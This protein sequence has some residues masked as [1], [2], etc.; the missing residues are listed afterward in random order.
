[1]RKAALSLAVASAIALTA[2]PAYAAT[3][4]VVVHDLA[5][6]RDQQTAVQDYWTAGRIA[7]MP[8]GPT[9]PGGPAQ[10]GPDGAGWAPGTLTDR[11]IGRL[12]FV[13]RDG[14]DASCTATVLPSAGQSVIVTAGHCVHELNLI[15]EDPKWTGNLLFVPGFRDNTRPF[16]SFTARAS[17][18]DRTWT[19]DDQHTGHDQAFLVLN[20]RVPGVPQGIALDVP[21]G[22]PVQEFGYPRA[23]GRPGH[24]GRPEFTGQRLAHCWATAVEDPGPPDFPQDRGV[25][26]VPCDMGGGASGG[27]RLAHFTEHA[28]VGLVVGVDVQS[29]F[30]DPAGTGC[31]SGDQRC[32][33]HLVGPQFTTA[34]TGPLYSRALTLALR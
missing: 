10:D 33:R 3:D 25:W 14:D 30:I 18:V 29:A 31:D 17:I 11:S 27:P 23:A 16:G 21:G 5:V 12:F 8:T 24:Q 19:A 9:G 20:G 7:A 28:G 6:G 15:G 26:G 2:A 34:I 22:L 32:T 4:G 1:M 13:D